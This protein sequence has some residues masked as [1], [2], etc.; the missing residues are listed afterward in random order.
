LA[1]GPAV[2][3]SAATPA[4][5]SDFS[6]DS[7]DA[8]FT[9]GIDDEG[10][11]TTHVTETI[12]ARFPEYD[13]NR[14]I[15]RAIP[16]RDGEVP[17][18][19]TMRSITDER[20]ADVPYERDDRDGF[21]EFAL[22]TDDYVHGSTT[23][24][25]DYTMENTIRH[26]ADADVDEFYWDI[27]G[28]GWAQTFD[29]VSATVR[30]TGALA[31]ALTGDAT[32]Y[33]GYYASTDQCDLGRSDVTVDGARAIQFAA[34]AGPL[35][36]YS[37]MTVSIGFD[38]G[39][40]TQPPLARDH[41]IVT[42]APLLLLAIAGL[43][44]IVSIV[45]KTAVWRDKPGRGTI[46][47]QYEPPQEEDESLLLDANLIG[48]P[49]AG[50]PAQFVDFAVRGM[51]RVID[52]APGDTSL[53]DRMRFVLELVTADGANAQELRVLVILF[54]A[55]LR[56]GAR[57]HP[58]A[59][60]ADIGAS[61]YGIASSTAAYAM[62]AGYRYEPVSRAPRILGRIA[63]WTV[64]AFVPIWFWAGGQDVITG[65]VVWPSVGT[66]VLAIA[67][68][69]VLSRPRRLS[70]KGALAREYLLGM[71]EYLTIAEEERLR[72]LQSPGGAERIDAT[73]R[74]A[75]VKLYERLLPYAVLWGVEDQWAQQLTAR[76]EGATPAWLDSTSFD[77]AVLRSFTLSSTSSVRPIVTSSSSG[78]SSWS[79]SGGSS[80]SSGSSGG[81]FS[82][83]G[84]GGGGGGGR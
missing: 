19:V 26:F 6:F 64:V 56:P 16:L 50:L 35:Y 84:G 78:G 25:L 22:G 69:A 49:S 55:S 20:G 82:G 21:A 62:K 33:F 2:V 66:L 29:S 65:A 54:G 28:T 68:P 58:G 34:Q 53:N 13:Q 31:D 48:R 81:G 70:T 11:A 27:N 36:P 43:L 32:C 79:S 51:V 46:V 67:V 24:I 9:L 37:T 7:F 52:T 23:Y 3:A 61:L 71:R 39:T 72:M 41:W 76:Y 17:L 12:V 4:D 14:G 83:G 47:A 57:V 80:F 1:V 38:S 75:I 44:V 5:V 74:E 8:E 63:F 45:F 42:L 18:E 60:S 59:L 73:D 40:V 30:V 10:H 77:A 15:I